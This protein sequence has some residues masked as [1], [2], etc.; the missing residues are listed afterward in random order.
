[1]TAPEVL[2]RYETRLLELQ[3]SLQELRL[4]HSATAVVLGFSVGLILLLGLNAVRHRVAMWWP[5]VPVP[6]VAAAAPRFRRVRLATSREWRLKRVYERAERR[7]NGLWAGEGCAGDE[8]HDADHPYARDLS[9]FGE[10][11]LFEL[12]CIARTAIGRRGLANYLLAAPALEET[13]ARQEAVKEL[14]QCTGLREQVA[15]LGEFE[16]AESRWETFN[17]WLNAPPVPFS[18]TLRVAA[19]IT[20]AMVL[21][22]L[23]AGLLGVLPWA[24]TAICILPLALF[25]SAAGLICRD[26]V[27]E[28]VESLRAASL[29]TRVLR[30]GLQLL[31]RQRFQSA[32]LV[33]IT[34]RVRGAALSVRRLEWLLNA[35]H[36]RNKDWFYQASLLLMGG[37]QLCMA[38]EQWRA[39][40]GGA[41]RDWIESWGEFEAL[42]ALANYA[43]ENPG[44]TFPEFSESKA[45]FEA[46]ALGHPLL[47]DETCVRND[48]RLNGETRFYVVS[49][50]NMSGKSSLLRA[51]GLNAVLAF[52]G[53]PVRAGTLRLSPLAVCASISVVDSLLKGKSKFLAEVDRVRLT[54]QLATGSRTVLFLIDEIFSGTNSRDRRAAAEAVIRTLVDRGAIGALST[55]D[56]SL[57]EIADAP[58]IH[59]ANVHLGAR[60]G[61]DPMSFDYR[62]KPGITTE[63]NALA[64]ARMAGV[65][66]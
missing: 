28:M 37:T 32:K 11:S 46:A 42:N 7:M 53:A 17:D 5:L 4:E 49:G 26:R 34:E 51:M 19:G 35:L 48:V 12:V 40:H 1:M 8:Y 24:R 27:R 20:S 14:Q 21:G 55:H 30:E 54:I 18:A 10:G 63:T 50:S 47:P 65:P 6:V 39:Q 43:W 29:E 9:I 66:V 33:R 23:L 36:E 15:V 56:I 62:L 13:R 52:A 2:I 45:L 58:E 38:I 61:G 25:H 3:A 22:I 44:H 31:E 57:T 41:L 64:I 59:G 60:D 16:A